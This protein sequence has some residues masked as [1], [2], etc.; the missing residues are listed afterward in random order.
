VSRAPSLVSRSRA[1]ATALAR[2]SAWPLAVYAI[3]RAVVLGAF[4]AG[5]RTRG[6]LSFHGIITTL[7]QWDGAWYVKLADEGYPSFVP[8][9]AGRAA[10]STLA[11]F[12]AFPALMR[13]VET[14]LGVSYIAAGVI[15]A[16]VFG[17]VAVVLLRNLVRRY[18]APDT[19]RRTVIFFCFFPGA[20]VLSMVYTESLMISA[21]LACLLALL[22]RRWLLAG[23]CAAVASG[24]RPNGIIVG[25]ACAWAAFEAIRNDRDWRALV[26]PLLAPVGIIAS[27]VYIGARSGERLAWFRVQREAWHERIDFGEEVVDRLWEVIEHPL[28]DTYALVTT[29]GLLFTI[30]ALV[31]LI[32][33]R[34]PAI[35]VVYTIGMVLL[36]VVSET[37]GLRPRFVLTAFP[38]LI[39][40]AHHV[41][42]ES[43]STLVATSGA[44]LAAIVAITVTTVELPP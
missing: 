20:F 28:E 9:E 27:L 44:G 38:L 24:T 10:W 19:A 8:E 5:M 37:L 3:S 21:V 34:P 33:M 29:L 22:D 31:L 18:I 6:D 36:T 7:A 1:R 43:F 12:P 30:A 35:L 25:L 42:A 40:V 41:R 23:I 11:F 4:A 26:A 13:V 14:V 16:H 39:A 2:D 15:V 17:A 32:R